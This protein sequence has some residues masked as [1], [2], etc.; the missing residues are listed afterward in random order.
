M[1]IYNK[2]VIDISSGE[3]LFEDSF[4]YDGPILFLKGGGTT[5]TTSV[6]AA[7]NARMATIAEQQQGMAKE[8]FDYWK[9]SQQPLETAQSQAALSLLP[10]QTE[11]MKS[12]IESQKS[13]LPTQTNVA[14]SYYDQV[15]GGVN[16]GERMGMARADVQQ[17]TSLTEGERRREFA[18]MG[19]DP[20]S[21][22]FASI[23][24]NDLRNKTKLMVGASTTAR[25]NAE[26]EQMNRLTQAASTL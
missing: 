3:V 22:A 21:P 14:K 17:A 26:Q 2:L 12:Q 5:S 24:A 10:G 23:R 19:V 25:R 16:V 15:L 9:T 8:Y 6:D 4:E 20:S 13:L 1:K 18:R 11:L 7:Y